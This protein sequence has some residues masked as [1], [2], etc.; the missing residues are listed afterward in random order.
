MDKPKNAKNNGKNE[1][2]TAI[3]NQVEGH[4]SAYVP[5]FCQAFGIKAGIMLS[6]LLYWQVRYPDS[7][8]YVSVGDMYAQTGL[9]AEEQRT[10]R[11][12]LINSGLITARI[13]SVPPVWHYRVNIMAVIEKCR[14]SRKSII[15][16]VNY[17]ESLLLEKSINNYR[18]SP[19]LIIEKL[20]NQLSRNSINLNMNH[21]I[22]TKD[23]NIKLHKP[24]PPSENEIFDDDQSPIE[25]EEVSQ[26]VWLSESLL[27]DL[28]DFGVFENNITEV[29]EAV[30]V[31]WSEE[32]I[33]ELMAKVEDDHLAGR[34]QSKPGTLLHRLRNLKP[35]KPKTNKF[36]ICPYCGQY[37]CECDAQWA[38]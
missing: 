34:V 7:D 5:E 14:L 32:A 6:Q 28:R 15:E 33:R 38:K 17:R 36:K 4:V 16:K 8:F 22:T 9:N 11:R 23:Y 13:T 19:S 31:G 10:A 25:E 29:E 1:A 35:P 20:D 30:K 18:E 2:F 27:D 12:S 21:K 3:V 37:P 24:P 26:G